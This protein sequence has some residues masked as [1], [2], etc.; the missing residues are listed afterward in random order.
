MK[1]KKV[2]AERPKVGQVW[3]Y[4]EDIFK[5]MIEPTTLMLVTEELERF[6]IAGGKIV[7]FIGCMNIISGEVCIVCAIPCRFIRRIPEA[8]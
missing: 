1:T 4:N 5:G 2:R 7:S 6:E 3:E 8:E